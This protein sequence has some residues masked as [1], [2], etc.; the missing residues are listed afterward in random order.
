MRYF[1]VFGLCLFFTNCAATQPQKSPDVQKRTTKQ[2]ASIERVVWIEVES[3]NEFWSTLKQSDLN[4]ALIGTEICPPC[5]IAKHWWEE[6]IAPPGWQF[7]YWQLGPQDDI[8][9]RHIKDVFRNLQQKDNLELPYL[10][11]IEKSANPAKQQSI[12]VTF[13]SLSGCTKEAQ[14]FLVMHPHGTIRF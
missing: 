7:V 6:K 1:A 13:R 10:S 3:G 11:I 8:L 5:K 12:T 2:E 14:E 4:V 9:T